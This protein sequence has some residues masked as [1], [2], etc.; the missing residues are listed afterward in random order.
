MRF[1]PGRADLQ[2]DETGLPYGV[3]ASGGHIR[4]VNEKHPKLLCVRRD[5][6]A[7]DFLSFSA[8]WPF[9][10][11]CVMSAKTVEDML[12]WIEEHIEED[13]D[14]PRMAKF[15]GYSDFYCSAKFHEYVGESFRQYTL[16]RRLALAADTLRKSD[17]NILQIALQYGFS[18]HEAFARAFKK[19]YGCSPKAYRS[20]QTGGVPAAPVCSQ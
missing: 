15:V 9:M 4:I 16:R 13:P 8:P 18:S 6:A 2:T 19:A 11:V 12:Q 3:P 1:C 10:E 17:L 5:W 20:G 7:S 14:L